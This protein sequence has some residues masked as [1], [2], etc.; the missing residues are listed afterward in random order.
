MN[1]GYE[2]SIFENFNSLF[3]NRVRPEFF[4][5][6]FIDPLC[7]KDLSSPLSS[8]Q[9]FLSPTIEMLTYFSNENLAMLRMNYEGTRS[10]KFKP[11]TPDE[12]TEFFIYNSALMAYKEGFIIIEISINFRGYWSYEV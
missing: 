9:S 7:D 5:V 1:R 2:K 10:N 8:L 11:V 4:D 3:Y 6:P 12:L